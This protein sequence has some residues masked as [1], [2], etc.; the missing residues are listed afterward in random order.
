MQPKIVFIV[1]PK[2]GKG[3]G[4]DA[5]IDA[6]YDAAKK[7]G[8]GA[9]V[10]ET[11]GVQDAERFA[12]TF[13]KNNPE[14]EIRLYACGG[15]GTMNE[16]LNA[17]MTHQAATGK[18]NV[19][20]GL[21]P[22]GS[23]ND[24]CKNFGSLKRALNI[25]AQLKADPIPSDA[26]RFVE[27]VDGKEKVRYCANMFNIGFDCNTADLAAN[28]KKIPLVTGS[29]AYLI[30]VF[31]NLIQ[32]RG[33]NLRI[34]VDGEV[35]HEG[36]LLLN[37]IAN[38]PYC[39]GGIKSNPTASIHDGLMDINVVSDIS[40]IAML[41]LLPRY[42]KGTHMEMKE[43]EKFIKV[44]TAKEVVITPLDKSMRLCTDGEISD[45]GEITITV[46]RDAFWFLKPQS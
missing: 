25:E 13:I 1:N 31:T 10:Y 8:E 29:M 33:A 45:S 32:K 2:A 9:W 17:V 36:K 26:L 4:V 18:K 39:G 7:E 35:V 14:D 12:T 3:K 43:V 40:R 5:L 42:M 15:D 20:I 6:I 37:S 23:G 24:F 34:K 22:I 46:E 27:V 28:Y 11:K 41:K 44:Y 30:S 21:V 16:V 19:C 38:G